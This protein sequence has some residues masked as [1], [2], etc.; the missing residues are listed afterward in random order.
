M[1][2]EVLLQDPAIR[3]KEDRR[4]WA[5]HIQAH[6]KF[7]DFGGF[8][9]GYIDLLFEHEGR[10]FVADYKSN[11]LDGYGEVALEHAM[12]EHHY[13]L[14]ARLYVLALHRHLRAHLPDYDYEKHVGGVFYLFVREFRDEGIWFERPTRDALRHLEN[15]FIPAQP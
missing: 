6:W 9:Q 12:G 8:L 3:E 4:A 10:W 15:L 13:L 7:G 14:Q 1:L 5:Q 11:R 2:G